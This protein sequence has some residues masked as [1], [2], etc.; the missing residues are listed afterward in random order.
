MM[1]I[2]EDEATVLSHDITYQTLT[3]LEGQVTKAEQNWAAAG[4]STGL[5][6]AALKRAE[7]HESQC[8]DAV[9]RIKQAWSLVGE[10]LAPAEYG[11]E[12][13]AGEVHDGPADAGIKLPYF[14]PTVTSIEPS[15]EQAG[16]L[17]AQA[18][19]LVAERDRAHA[20]R[21]A[22]HLAARENELL[23]ERAAVRSSQIGSRLATAHDKN[24]KGF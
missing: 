20:S 10:N 14:P 4:D 11:S 6:R 22:Q 12:V 7:L 21:L 3:Y 17:V 5:A 18:N 9:D 19:A 23:V 1:E 15:L 8:L 24:Q 2:N 13:A 16:A